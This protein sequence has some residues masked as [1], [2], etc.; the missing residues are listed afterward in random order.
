MSA[1]HC[2]TAS[3]SS[4]SL[5]ADLGRIHR[6]DAHHGRAVASRSWASSPGRAHQSQ[7]RAGRRL[8]PRWRRPS[9]CS[10]ER[11][12]IP[13]VRRRSAR[14]ATQILPLLRRSAGDCHRDLLRIFADVAIVR[15]LT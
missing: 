10:F 13:W 15:L 14:R 5:R 1:T 12:A 7:H 4:T 6:P 11:P 8:P 2:G 3:S 9:D